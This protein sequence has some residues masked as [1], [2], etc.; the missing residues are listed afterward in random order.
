MTVADIKKWKK[1]I[2]DD[3]TILQKDL[4]YMSYSQRECLNNLK[5][6]EIRDGGNTAFHHFRKSEGGTGIQIIR[7]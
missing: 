6:T 1:I 4:S 5:I 2:L 7:S 3:R